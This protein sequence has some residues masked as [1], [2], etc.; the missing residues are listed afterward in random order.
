MNTLQL[1]LLVSS[2]AADAPLEPTSALMSI[3]MISETT[4]TIPVR[5][6]LIQMHIV[7]S[8]SAARPSSGVRSAALASISIQEMEEL[9]EGVIGH[10]VPSVTHLLPLGLHVVVLVLLKILVIRLR[11]K[12]RSIRF[13][14][15]IIHIRE[16][17]V[18]ELGLVVVIADVH[19]TIVAVVVGRGHQPS[20][21]VI[22]IIGKGW[23]L[24][25]ATHFITA[26]RHFLHFRIVALFL[27]ALFHS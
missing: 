7:L 9:Y 17:H 4:W 25:R 10:V 2:G 27:A 18:A 26:S 8:V 20:R 16:A 11:L 13:R 1:V 3:V 14:V 22:V 15:K 12:R 6:S 24:F 21:R 19:L 23:E 5:V